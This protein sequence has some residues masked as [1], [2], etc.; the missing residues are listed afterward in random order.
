MYQIVQYVHGWNFDFCLTQNNK[1][2]AVLNFTLSHIIWYYM[3]SKC[4]EK[5]GPQE[6]KKQ[7]GFII[8][9]Q[10]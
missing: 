2:T 9:H 6:N 7:T 4:W 10:K 1:P 5:K 3:Y 8:S